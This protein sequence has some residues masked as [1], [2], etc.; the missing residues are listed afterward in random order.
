MTESEWLS[1]A[2][3]DA[4]LRRACDWRYVRKARLFAVAYGY[5]AL[6]LV[7]V[8]PKSFYRIVAAAEARA[9][10]RATDLDLHAAV[11]EAYA[12]TQ[13]AGSP[14]I[15]LGLYWVLQHPCQHPI[16][17]NA[18]VVLRG[19]T[20]LAA[21]TAA[22]PAVGPD[23]PTRDQIIAEERQ[24]QCDLIRDIVGNPFRPALIDTRWLTST[25]VALAETIYQDRA[26]DRLPILADALQD[27]G[28]G[29]EQVLQHC[30]GPG[31]HVRGCWV[32]DLVTGRG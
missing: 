27:A 14:A 25:V 16:G 30:R 17:G 9:D 15:L 20:D 32:V 26:F 22:L 10:D 7:P 28:C 18:V 2:A 13:A 23:R 29:D 24:R 21:E 11:T 12:E 3:Y 19:A 8:A 4:M 1:G 6:G 31:P 5:R